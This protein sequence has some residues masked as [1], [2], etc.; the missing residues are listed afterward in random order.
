MAQMERKENIEWKRASEVFPN[1]TLFGVNGITMEDLV[2]GFV[3]NS[4]FISAMST[5][6]EYPGRIEKLFLNNINE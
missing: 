3:V 6:A 4:W 1:S 2:Q 5:L